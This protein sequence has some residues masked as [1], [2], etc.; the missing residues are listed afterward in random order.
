MAED[1]FIIKESILLTCGETEEAED[2]AIIKSCF[3]FISEYNGMK[4]RGMIAVPGVKEAGEVL[5]KTELA[6][7]EKL[8]H[9][10]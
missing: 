8:G 5:Q 4:V 10:I 1:I 7:A 2:F 3:R 6:Q 9:E